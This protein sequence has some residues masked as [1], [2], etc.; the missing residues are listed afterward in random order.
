MKKL[1]IILFLVLFIKPNYSQEPPYKNPKLSIEKRVEDLLSRMT[2]EEK[3]WQLYMIPG[4]LSEEKDKFRNGIFGLQLNTRAKSNNTAEQMM[5]YGSSGSAESEAK[6][7]NEIQKYFVNETRLGIPVIPFDEALHG[8]IRPGATAFPQSIGLAAAFDTSLMHKV[9]HAIASE[10]RSRGIRQVLSPVINIARDVR[11]GRTEES[12]GEDPFLT[13]EMGVAFISEFEKLK[14][15]ATPKH[16]VAN[17]GAGGRDSYPINFN[18]RLM[19]Q[20]YFPAFK[21][22]VQKA[23]ATSIMISY[24]SYDGTPCTANDWLLNQTL[25][26]D[27]GFKGYVISDAGAIG[28]AND[29]HFTSHNYTEST[30]KAIDAGLDVILQTSYSQYPIFYDAFKKGLIKESVID[31]AVRRVLTAKFKMGLF[32]NPYVNADEA[33]KLN[34]SS[35]HR[36]LAE[37]AAEESIVLLKNENN[38][39]PLKKDLKKIAVI[40]TDA[41]EGRLGGYSRP[42]GNVVNILDGIKDKVKG[43]ADVEYT[44]GPGRENIEFIPVPPEYLSCVYNGI[45]EEG[46]IGKYFNNPEFDG[47]PALT[48]NDKVIDFRW[49]LFPPDQKIIER[50]WY[51]VMW[52]G[53]IIGPEDGKVNIGIEG[54]DGYKLFIN[55]KLIINNWI[56]KSYGTATFPYEFQK[57]K[58]YNIKIQ[59]Y[60]T[61]GNVKVKLIWDA[62]VRNNWQQEINKAV[63]LAKQSDVAIIAAGIDEGEFRDRA[64]LRLPGHQEELIK[65]VAETGTPTVVILVGGSAIT[66]ENWI[67]K[68]PGILDVWYPGE[69]GGDAVANVLFGDYN[70]AG[71]LPVT[72]PVFEGQLP[73][74]YNHE[75]TG[76][77]DDYVNLTGQ[78]L[79]PFGYGLSYTKFEYSGLTFDKKEITPNENIIASF[80]IK[81]TGKADGDEV[82]QLYIRDI[83]SSVATPVM[84]LKGFKR[85]HLT[86]GETR[87]VQFNITPDLLSMINKKLQRVVEPGDFKIMIGASSKD[88]RLMDKIKVK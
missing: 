66:M 57:G 39:L 64:I 6:E 21:A 44:P 32:E 16:F 29:L 23:D 36:K 43:I 4:D 58:D 68:I 34:D 3:F 63:D 65:E 18:K 67:N 20:I 84:E 85:I 88:I 1:F 50:D 38:I 45:K 77:G 62:G 19:D 60:T 72:F 71:R 70:P 81:N 48:R 74:Y 80:K 2:P 40:G 49:T 28:G 76:R 33:K 22:A 51:S 69:M 46:L 27:W 42:P 26:K 78:P 30:K 15:A 73:L 14:V 61:D 13:S 12:Y 35:E 8:L 9:A 53:K 24:N 25:K 5:D 83:Y 17:V 11:W 75:P 59:F 87:E 31:S 54:N 55:D 7:I 37:Q 47:E 52:E 79:F 86:A 41:V 56:Q 10:V 82:A